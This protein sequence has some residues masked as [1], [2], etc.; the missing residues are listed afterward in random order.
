[1]TKSNKIRQ[2]LALFVVVATLSLIAA[3][4]LKVYRGKG[5]E[6]LLRKLPKNIDVSLQKIHF[7]ET[8]D[9]KKKWDL[10]ADKAEYDKK[11]EVTHL[12]GVRL[13]VA[14][15]SAMG[16]ITLTAHRADYHH[17]TK[18]VT[19][20]GEVVAR[21]ASG[22]VFTTSSAAYIA[23]RSAIT[24]SSPVRFTDG[25]LTLEGVGMEFLTETKNLRLLSKVTANIMPGAGK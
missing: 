15:D 2:L 1:M 6:G 7:T 25:R 10:V 19:L 13:V 11:G 8:G 4:A 17:I 21:S 12:N 9:E 18:N 14:G 22:M 24:T 23:A 16:D 20:S 5:T 3:I